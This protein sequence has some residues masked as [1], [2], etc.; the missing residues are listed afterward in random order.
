MG[1]WRHPNL[2]LDD[3]G[4]ATLLVHLGSSR[5]GDPEFL[6]GADHEEEESVRLHQEAPQGRSRWYRRDRQGIRGVTEETTTGVHRLYEMQKEGTLLFPAIN[7]NDSVT[8]CKFDD[9][10]G[11]TKA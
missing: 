8:K 1:R 3:G 6:D 4:D 2:I 5:E 11:S 7:V 9:L 10:Y